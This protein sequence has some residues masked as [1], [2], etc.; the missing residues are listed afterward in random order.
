MSI[1][2]ATQ[3]YVR[4]ENKGTRYTIWLIPTASGNNWGSRDEG[5]DKA[6]TVGKRKGRRRHD[7]NTIKNQLHYI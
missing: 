3:L 7:K 1:I 4:G 5:S 2:S 6:E